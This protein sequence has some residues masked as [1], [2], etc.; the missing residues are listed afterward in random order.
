MLNDPD[1]HD[2]ADN[3][4]LS[5]VSETIQGLVDIMQHKVESA[6]SCMEE[7][8]MIANPDKFKAIIIIKDKQQTENYEL[9]FKGK[10]ISSSKN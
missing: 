3:N 10:S 7:N 5:A 9:N 2:F 8:D 4:T 1:L 6:V